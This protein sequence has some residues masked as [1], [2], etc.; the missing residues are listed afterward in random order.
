MRSNALSNVC[1]YIATALS[2]I[3]AI[4]SARFINGS[5]FVNGSANIGAIYS[6]VMVFLLPIIAIWGGAALVK[7]V[8]S[9][10]NN[11]RYITF[12]LEQIRKNEEKTNALQ[13]SLLNTE[14]EIKNSF[15]LQELNVLIAD[16]NEVLSDIIKR[17]NSV[18]SA[19]IEHLWSRTAGG[20]RWLLAKTFIEINNYQANFAENLLDKAKKNGLLKGSIL[21]FYHRYQNLNK[22]LASFDKDRS[23]FDMIEFG[24]L[25]KVFSILTPVAEGLYSD[26]KNSV[27]EIKTTKQAEM[28]SQY[29]MVFPSFLSQEVS[30]KA[31]KTKD[32]FVNDT[33]STID[34][35]LEAI[36]DEL[37]SVKS[38]ENKYG[39]TEFSKTRQA[40]NNLKMQ[41]NKKA[42][43]KKII[44]IE[45]LEKE[46]NSSPENN[47]NEYDYPL[48]AINNDKNN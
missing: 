9:E 38:N 18:S 19:Q 45:E 35:N 4:Y 41:T 46:I 15:M 10:K 44:S 31:D 40:L 39:V 23:F 36:R 24:A 20:E 3:W 11:N 47:Y 22:L 34:S 29:D 5:I 33:V 14:K 25:G 37:L 26:K 27:E 12:L 28:P 42:K 17:S 16:M 6:S 32:L 13:Q 2:T 21:E 48:G 43:N 8:L 7:M 1:F 30:D